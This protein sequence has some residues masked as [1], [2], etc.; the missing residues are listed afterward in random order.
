MDDQQLWFA[1]FLA[2]A[3]DFASS[4]NERGAL[5][6]STIGKRARDLLHLDDKTIDSLVQL[7]PVFQTEDGWP[8]AW[9]AAKL[10][11]RRTN[12]SEDLRRRVATFAQTVAPRGLRQRVVAKLHSRELFD[13]EDFEVDQYVEREQESQFEAVS[14]GKEL[15]KDKA[16]LME[17]LPRLMDRGSRGMPF[18]L[19]QGVAAAA[20][21]IPS[22]LGAIGRI[23]GDTDESRLSTLFLRG[24]MSGWSERDLNQTNAFLDNSIR[25]PIWARW[26]SELQLAVVFDDRALVRTIDAIE[27][28]AA[29]VEDFTWLSMGRTL[30]PHRVVEF[31]RLI[32]TLARRGMSGVHTALDTL[33]MQ[34][35]SSKELAKSEQAELGAYCLSFLL[36]YDWTSLKVDQ[37][38]VEHEL[39]QVFDY[40]AR[41]A[42]G[43]ES[44][45]DLI[46]K[47][48][49][50][51][52]GSG[53]FDRNSKGRLIGPA[54]MRFPEQCLTYLM[55]HPL[56]SQSEDAAELLLLESSSA[57]RGLSNHVP[58]EVL[59][60]WIMKDPDLRAKFA[61]RMCRLEAATSTQEIDEGGAFS[62]AR[63]IYE[64]S[65]DKLSAVAILGS[66]LIS[67][68]F[69]SREIPHMS[70]GIKMLDTLPAPATQKEAEE[71]RRIRKELSNRIEW[72]TDLGRSSR[73][74]P[75]GFE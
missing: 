47:V 67:S 43:F 17:M 5:V 69:S 40:A 41:H 70:S 28:G 7:T 19:G 27:H 2:V 53:L 60:I 21:D 26:Y 48:I 3:G 9:T 75:E 31:G 55:S 25:S 11:L 61:M 54:L 45:K 4:A 63:R 23:L 66:R 33:H 38:M 14:V 24:V 74:E 50:H 29:P 72:M 22:L 32:D 56:L 68:S 13:D 37:T 12:I 65:T 8:E 39:E 42:S 10:L 1:E 18:S 30:A 57:E 51:R 52:R 58:D 62:L 64:L 73:R 49:K 6:R 46:D 59:L 36:R 15:G 71:R 44:L 20:E 16:L 35:F 34:V